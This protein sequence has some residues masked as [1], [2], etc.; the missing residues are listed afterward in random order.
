MKNI[1][2]L[3]RDADP[4]RYEPT[5]PSGQYDVRRGA[6]RAAASAVP[7]PA[8][9]GSRSRMAIFATVA[10]TV[11]AVSILGSR[12]RSLFVSDLQAAA[13]RFEVRLAEDNP[14]PGL[15]E[16]KVSGSDRAVFLHDQVI[17]TN[18]DIAAARVIPGHG[19]SEYSVGIEF[20]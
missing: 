7:A 11:I 6:I 18:S 1:S 17:V 19:P 13:V 2:E 3:L 5:C 9:V 8:M 4:L 12:V 10:L 14:A 15:R 16:A 20:K